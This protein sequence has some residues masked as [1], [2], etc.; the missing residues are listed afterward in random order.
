LI[1]RP[2]V[3]ISR[4]L[5][6]L[7]ALAAALSAG[8]ASA[9]AA[10]PCAAGDSARADTAGAAVRIIA[11][12]TIAELRFDAQPRATVRT[13]GC[14]GAASPV[15]VIERRNL[16]E[17]VEPGVTYRD[18]YVAVEILGRVEA[19]CITALAG[20]ASLAGICDSAVRGD[21]ARAPPP[22]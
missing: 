13:T 15:R 5:L 7:A 12:V 17:R 6:R 11:S 8:R 9:Q 22:R 20:D 4:R 14:G 10:A 21:T 16:P 3:T 18:V 1:G 2:C 19:A